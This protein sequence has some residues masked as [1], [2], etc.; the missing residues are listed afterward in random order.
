M[1]TA[2]SNYKLQMQTLLSHFSTDYFKIGIYGNI[3]TRPIYKLPQC[4]IHNYSIESIAKFRKQNCYKLF[5][6]LWDIHSL[7]FMLS[8]L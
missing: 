2:L 3:R 4:K 6:F 8:Y 7:L 5:L 1:T